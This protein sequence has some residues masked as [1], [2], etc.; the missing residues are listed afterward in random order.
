MKKVFILVVLVLSVGYASAQKLD[1]NTEALP[2][3]KKARK[4]GQ[5]SG[6]YWD[7]SGEKLQTI[8]TYREK[9]KSP[10]SYDLINVSLDG[11][12]TGPETELLTP[13]N[14]S[15]LDLQI[16]ETL[17]EED[18]FENFDQEMVWIKRVDLGWNAVAFDGYFE[19]QSDIYGF[20]GYE[21]QKESNKTRL[22][23]D[24]NQSL[25]LD[26]V[27][28]DGPMVEKYSS[29]VLSQGFLG[30][31]SLS[32]YAFVP[33]GDKVIIG[34]L[35]NGRVKI[36]LDASPDWLTTRYL[37]GTYN[38]GTMEWEEQNFIE[39]DY[40]MHTLASLKT[41]D[42]VAVL[43]RKDTKGT[44]ENNKVR[45]N[46]SEYKGVVMLLFDNKG[47]LTSQLDLDFGD[48][49]FPPIGTS[50]SNTIPPKFDIRKVKDSYYVSAVGFGRGTQFESLNI[51]KITDGQI[52]FRKKFL[53]DDLNDFVTPDGEKVK[54][55]I[56]KREVPV[57]DEIIASDDEVL[58]LGSIKEIGNFVIRLDANTGSL[59]QLIA[60]EHW[61]P[62]QGVTIPLGVRGWS[63]TKSSRSSEGFL[64][65][66][67]TVEEH[68]DYYYIL[69]RKM[70][71]GMTP[72]SS[73]SS[74]SSSSN[75]VI[76][77]TYTKSVRIDELFA[78]A[79]LVLINKKTGAI[80]EPLVIDDEILVG[81]YGMYVGKDGT[82]FLH[83]YDGKK[84]QMTSVKI[85]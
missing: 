40:T 42:G 18:E 43:L 48:F 7:V 5:Y 11:K 29:K 27:L 36:G 23:G 33:K 78:F 25:M 38:T 37:V 62:K 52:D 73:V 15:K 75:G 30:L 31:S 10:R 57:I 50:L 12:I 20:V 61:V 59:N 34:G 60:S 46:D 67:V 1:V 81:A 84:Y 82:A 4:F 22:M 63:K 13:D 55:L 35:M 77:T 19:P 9:R 3:S 8:Y 80:A 49:N 14:I 72:G 26:F 16:D 39:F 64:E 24:E 69:Y 71:L 79:K 28:A 45:F 51:Y 85:K 56:K 17:L 47:K 83:G 76:K 58:F 65:Y 2:I 54:Y 41:D 70:N 21:F 66:P 68:G 74:T 53:T 6:S 44:I 32:T